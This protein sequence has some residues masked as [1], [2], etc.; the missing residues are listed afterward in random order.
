MLRTGLRTLFAQAAPRALAC[1]CL[2]RQIVARPFSSTSSTR[3]IADDFVNIIQADAARPIPQVATL[4]ASTG[5]TL[6]DG[7]VVP[8]PVI[9]INGVVFLWDV[10][11]P[12]ELEWEGFNEEYWKLFEIIT[13]RPGSCPGLDI[14]LVGTGKRGLFPPPKFKKYLNGLGI[15]VDVLDSRNASSTYNLLAEE[16]RRVAA[17]LYPVGSLDARTGLPWVRDLKLPA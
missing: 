6:A 9:L 2:P 16:G 5:F 13:P 14:L 1:T 4:S 15:Q 12:G 7:L 17:A 11:P 10:M 8:S 3:R